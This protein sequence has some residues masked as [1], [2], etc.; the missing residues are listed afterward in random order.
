MS[1]SNNNYNQ[2]GAFTIECPGRN[3][4]VFRFGTSYMCHP[5]NVMFWGLIESKFDEHQ[6]ATQE[7]KVAIT[8]WIIQEVEEARQG[9]FLTWNNKVGSWLVMKDRAQIRNKIAV[10]FREQKK[11][12]KARENCRVYESSTYEFERQDGGK[13]K[14]VNGVEVDSCNCMPSTS[15]IPATS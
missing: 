5:G 8:W 15:A 14:R 12:T 11:R 7:G 6:N 3:D 2:N 4:V 1:K 10:C 13:R 9:R